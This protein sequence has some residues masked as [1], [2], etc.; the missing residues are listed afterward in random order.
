[1]LFVTRRRAELKFAL[2]SDGELADATQRPKTNV[3][4][5]LPCRLVMMIGDTPDPSFANP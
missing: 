5:D 1:M 4:P 2:L 3:D